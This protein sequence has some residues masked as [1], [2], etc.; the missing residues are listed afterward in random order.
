M[1]QVFENA[2]TIMK[3][4]L[5]ILS[6]A[7]TIVIA[8]YCQAGQ[9]ISDQVQLVKLDMNSYFFYYFQMEGIFDTLTQCSW[10]NW[11]AKNKQILLIFMA[12]SLKRRSL[13]FAGI[14]IDY[15]QGVSVSIAN[16]FPRTNLNIV[17]GD[18]H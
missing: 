2:S 16:K 12:N 3:L 5:A 10:Y 8:L 13:T 15:K 1:F 18:A 9:K 7:T 11:D 17:A 14:A 4:R 6:I